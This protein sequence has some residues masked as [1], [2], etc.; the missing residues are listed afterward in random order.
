MVLAAENGTKATTIQD[1][2]PF[3]HLSRVELLCSSRSRNHVNYLIITIVPE[4][5]IIPVA[6]LDDQVPF[7]FGN[8]WKKWRLV[9]IS[10]PARWQ[11]LQAE[12]SIV[13]RSQI[14]KQ[15]L[16][17][18]WASS[19]KVFSI[20]IIVLRRFSWNL[21]AKKRSGFLTCRARG[22]GM[23]LAYVRDFETL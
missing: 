13:P 1:G 4:F 14:I 5:H 12:A 6:V 2:H 11:H 15:F 18:V 19:K 3:T 17:Q 20:C 7:F 22:W 10:R 9:R 8:D 16:L 21:T 23:R